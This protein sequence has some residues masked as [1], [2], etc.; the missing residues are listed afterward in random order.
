MNQIALVLNEYYNLNFKTAIIQGWFVIEFFINE[1]WNDFLN[2]KNS[3]LRLNSKGKLGKRLNKK[4]DE[5]LK[6]RDLTISI[7]SNILELNDFIPF[8]VFEDI[9]KVRKLRN[10][11]VH[12]LNPKEEIIRM[13]CKS[14]L[15]L[16]KYFLKSI[17][18]I[19]LDVNVRLVYNSLDIYSY[20]QVRQ[21]NH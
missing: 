19:E 15:D 3:E 4:R 21:G 9:D 17:Y 5:F 18:S 20:R 1:R 11:I 13:D 7:M 6:G 10:M 2:I 8:A 14:V 12:N 16:I